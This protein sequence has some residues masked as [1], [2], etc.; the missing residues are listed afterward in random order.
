MLNSSSPA[1]YLI[2]G[3]VMLCGSTFARRRL[4]SSSRGRDRNLES[5]TG[6][7]LGD[8]LLKLVLDQNRQ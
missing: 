5:S 3:L 6:R 1:V 2:V 4:S 8:K 7:P